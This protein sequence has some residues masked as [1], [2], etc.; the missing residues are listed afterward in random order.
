MKRHLLQLSLF[1]LLST[2]PALA[3]EERREA[4]DWTVLIYAAV[5]NDWEEPFMRDVRR[6]RKGLKGV[7]GVEV[8]LLIDRSPDY[9]R[10]KRALGEDFS[11]TRLYRL[12][13][14]EAE[15][16]NGE[17]ELRGLTE[18]SK[19]DLNTGDARTLRDFIRYGKRA[20][21]AERYAL[22]CV[23][24]GEGPMSCPDETTDDILF[25]AELT[26]VLGEEDSVDLLG[27]DACLMAGVENAYQW[28][29]REGSFGADYLV[30]SAPLS[31]SWPYEEICASLKKRPKGKEGLTAAAFGD[32]LVEELKDQI[33]G[34]R[35]DEEG[36]ERDLQ[37][38]GSFDLHAVSAAK[39]DLDLLATQLWKDEA[40]E[41]LLRL[42]GSGLEASTFVYVWPERNANRDMPH[43][44][45]T[46][47]CQRLA[48]DKSFSEE[49][50]GLAK[51]AA[52]SAEAVVSSSF[53]LKHYKG[54]SEGEHGLYLIFPEGDTKT[55]RG[56]T[57][58][59]R[60]GW[61]NALELEGD[62]DGYG[63][64]AWCSDGAT[65]GNGEVENW[66][67]LM[68]AWFDSAEPDEPG[69]SNGYA[70]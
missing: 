41:E 44:D 2:T 14:G 6:M 47:L 13:G 24:H 50:R 5:D 45:L 68:D 53:G 31:S 23:S 16:L 40:K 55:R 38:W 4:A 66:F 33:T 22:W 19:T 29:R 63:K 54:F 10:D 70:W 32:K 57:Y 48:K 52:E 26:D 35:S 58:W 12:S 60:M 67:E 3:A 56:K 42:R 18:T 62:E 39:R 64:Y 46:H 49:A 28:R 69:G 51:T 7:K 15:R 65:P 11:D 8:V 1:A 17:P 25:T 21:P 34:G 30:A 37:T 36:L 43:V 20:H 27:F 9:S 61:Y 59:S